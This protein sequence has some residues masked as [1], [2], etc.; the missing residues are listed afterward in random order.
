MQGTAHDESRLPSLSLCPEDRNL[1]VVEPQKVGRLDGAQSHLAKNSS[2]SF[3]LAWTQILL[4]QNQALFASRQ[5]L[6]PSIRFTAN[7]N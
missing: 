7:G 6:S 5:T 3:S 1:A 4:S 2:L